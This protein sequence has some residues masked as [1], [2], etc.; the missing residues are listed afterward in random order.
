M[1]DVSQFSQRTCRLM[2]PPREPRANIGT[3]PD[4]S[5]QMESLT[6]LHFG[7]RWCGSMFIQIFFWL[8]G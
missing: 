4:I 2:P 5:T 6:G 7:W 8:S 1:I 3:D